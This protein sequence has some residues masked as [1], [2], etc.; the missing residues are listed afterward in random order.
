MN[1][2]FKFNRENAR[3]ALALG[4][5]ERSIMDVLWDQGEMSG[6]DL[7]EKLGSKL[8]IRHNTLLTVCERLVAKGLASK[9]KKGKYSYYSPLLSR[10][11]FGKR[12]AGPL[13]KELFDVSSDS[14]LAAFV[15]S[16]SSDP[17]QLNY[18]KSLIEEAEKKKKGR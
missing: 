13:L 18:L 11:E 14:V 8:K 4:N 10:D 1:P 3:N 9:I 16:T 5:L 15:D 7:Y 6:N 12:I 2:K 17:D